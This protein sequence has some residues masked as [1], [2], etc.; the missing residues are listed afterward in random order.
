MEEPIELSLD[1][2]GGLID[3]RIEPEVTEDGNTLYSVTILY[4]NM[5]DGF[6]RSEIYCHTMVQ[7]P[8]THSFVFIEDEKGILPK[9]SALEPHISEAIIDHL[10]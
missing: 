2:P 8:A 7:D 3:C 6:S 4:P 9:I 5:I 10:R 1:S